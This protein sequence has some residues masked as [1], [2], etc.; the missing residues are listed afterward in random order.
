VSFDDAV[1]AA[2]EEIVEAV[3]DECYRLCQTAGKCP[4]GAPEVEAAIRK[5]LEPFFRW[6]PVEEGPPATT[7]GHSDPVAVILAPQ[8]CDVT[9]VI[10][11]TEYT[12]VDGWECS[13]RPVLYHVLPPLPENKCP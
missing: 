1:V 13:P 6:I 5:H 7:D 9:P 12:A 3:G 8:S 2:A 4:A 10:V 11:L